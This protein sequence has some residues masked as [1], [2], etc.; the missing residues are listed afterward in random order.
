MQV[1]MIKKYFFP[2]LFE[3]KLQT[4]WLF[5]PKYF[6]FTLKYFS[7]YFLGVRIFL[8]NHSTIVN[9]SKFDRDNIF[10]IY[11]QYSYYIINLTQ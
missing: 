2:K 3:S 1:T 5:T 10:V 4:S 11:P 6:L 8:Y 7:I 9:L